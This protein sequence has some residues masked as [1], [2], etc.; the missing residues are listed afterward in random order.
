MTSP[1]EEIRAV[2]DD[3]RQETMPYPPVSR[4]WWMIG[5]FAIAAVLQYT[6]RQILSLLVDPIRA[7]LGI[8]DTQISVLQGAAFAVLYSI[9]GLPLGRVADIFPR[10]WVIVAG[11]LLWSLATVASGLAADFNQLLLCRIGV[12]IGEAAL[13]PAAASMI[14]DS[15]APSRRGTAVGL[16]LM[17]QVIGG[18]AALAIGGYL[19]DLAVNGNLAWLPIIGTLAPWRIVL[20]LVGLP[21]L[22]VAAL[23]LSVAEPKRRHNENGTTAALPLIAVAR[24]FRARA[25]LLV[26]LYLANALISIGDYG[27]LAWSPAFLSRN[28]DFTP[29]AIGSILGGIAILTGIVGTAGG[30]YL[31][32][33]LSR[34][35]GASARLRV[36]FISSLFGVLGA[37]VGLAPTAT[38]V[39][40]ALTIWNLASAICGTVAI[41]AVLEALPNEMRGMG[42][43]LVAFCNTILGL[44]LGPTLV[45]LTTEH[46]FT[47]RNAVGLAMT[48]ITLP[49]AVLAIG[50]FYQALR[51]SPRSMPVSA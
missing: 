26:P 16:F 49:A 14:V 38:G 19:L 44:G 18:G 30:G 24:G 17:G 4:G 46:V 27:L 35:Y 42:T 29:S 25:G 3:V 36:V 40:L 9:V 12:G 22:V 5:V 50:L 23:L 32:D 34:R 33:R 39:L 41:T 11:V 6:D 43:S 15:F 48:L 21:G 2:G 51:V 28:F 47:D 31:A 1:S 37:C 7:D 8:S 13:A 45:A 10:R 20:V